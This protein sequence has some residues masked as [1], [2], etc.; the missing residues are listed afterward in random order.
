MVNCHGILRFSF[1]ARRPISVSLSQK[2]NGIRRCHIPAKLP[3]AG[4][5]LQLAGMGTMPFRVDGSHFCDPSSAPTAQAMLVLP[6]GRT[7]LPERR[8]QTPQ[9]PRRAHGPTN[10]RVTTARFAGGE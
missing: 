7:T 4:L 10:G 2:R 3:V 1:P 8:P 9:P 6:A 5:S